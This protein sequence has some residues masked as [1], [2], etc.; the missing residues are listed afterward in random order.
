MF[1]PPLRNHTN[2][3]A[4]TS[5]DITRISFQFIT[6]EKTILL[7]NIISISILLKKEQT[8]ST[9]CKFTVICDNFIYSREMCAYI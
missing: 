6:N 4:H 9:Y 8:L 1:L 7:A 5:E 2:G 3:N